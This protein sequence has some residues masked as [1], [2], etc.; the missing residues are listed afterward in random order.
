M[1]IRR[2][3]CKNKYVNFFFPNKATAQI[4]T[5]VR[6]RV[7][8]VGLLAGSQFVFGR[9]CDWPTLSMFSV[10]FLGPRAD[11]ELVSKFHAALHASHAARPMVNIKL[12]P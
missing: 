6:V 3:I 10:V 12:S 1:H 4:G 7:F 2:K 8:N 11:A 9:S 5:N